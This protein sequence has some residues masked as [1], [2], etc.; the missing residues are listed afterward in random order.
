MSRY[1]SDVGGGV[2]KKCLTLAID[3]QQFPENIFTILLRDTSTTLYRLSKT[4][5]SGTK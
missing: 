2:C 4:C 5:P 1:K 3:Y